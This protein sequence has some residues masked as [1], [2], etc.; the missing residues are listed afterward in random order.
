MDEL[1]FGACDR[2]YLCFRMFSVYR[3]IHFWRLME[4]R[5]QWSSEGDTEYVYYRV[6][7]S[8]R[9]LNAHTFFLDLPAW[10]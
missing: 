9:L 8:L 1:I 7:T 3:G 10:A 6:H 2:P 4:K 5:S